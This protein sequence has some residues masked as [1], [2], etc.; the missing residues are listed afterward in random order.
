MKALSKANSAELEKYLG[1]VVNWNNKIAWLREIADI[2]KEDKNI[3]A[4]MDNL[5][6]IEVEYGL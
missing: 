6:A 5:T 4:T 2:F 1:K 3:P